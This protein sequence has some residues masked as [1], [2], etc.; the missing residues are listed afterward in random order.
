MIFDNKGIGYIGGDFTSAGGLALADRIVG[1]NGSTWFHLPANLPSTQLVMA[2]LTIGDDLY[3]GSQ[4]SGTATTAEITVVT[5]PGTARAYP[6]ITIKRSGG[7]SATV[8][9]LRNETTGKTLYLNYALQSGETLTIDLTPG[10]RQIISSYRG[11]VWEAALR[12]SDLGD[13]YLLPG[14]NDI[15]VFVNQAGSPSMT[16]FMK[17][18]IAHESVDGVA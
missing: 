1:W 17:F 9:W 6:V 13:F 18:P 3:I 7:T 11:A 12:N 2:L 5:N 4:A 14:D 15:S 16:A 10:R 8:E